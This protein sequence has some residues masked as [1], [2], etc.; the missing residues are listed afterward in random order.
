MAF[1]MNILLQQLIE[2]GYN[3]ANNNLTVVPS[4][5]SDLRR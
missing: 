4:A 3:F 2:V 5:D 1:A